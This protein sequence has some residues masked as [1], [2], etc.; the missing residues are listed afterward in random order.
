[1]SSSEDLSWPSEAEEFIL[2]SS[3]QTDEQRLKVG[4]NGWQRRTTPDQNAIGMESNIT[5]ERL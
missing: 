3:N 4:H 2:S 5:L 1:M